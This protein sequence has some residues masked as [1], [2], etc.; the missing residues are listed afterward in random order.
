VFEF[1]T[2]VAWFLLPLPLLVWL[3]IPPAK[4]S[5]Q[6]ALILPFYADIKTLCEKKARVR[7]YR[8]SRLLACLVWVLGV[9]AL[10]GPQW[11]GKP[12]QMARAG[13]NILLAI[14]VS[15]SMETPDMLV[16]G[17]RYDR[18]SLVKAVAKRFIDKREGDRL[19]LI[20]FGSRAYLQTPLTY[21]RK[22]VKAQLED[23]TIGLAGQRTA[24]GDAIGAA[25]KRLSA[26]PQNARVLVLLTDGASNAGADPIQ[27]AKM[28]AKNHIRIY[29][30]GLGGDKIPVDTPFGVQYRQQSS[31]LDPHTLK[32]IADL[33]GG[34]FFRA[35]NP[36]SLV[37][38]YQRLNDLEPVTAES[39]AYRPVTPLYH[40]PLLAAFLIILGFLSRPVQ[41]SLTR[42][43]L[44]NVL[45]H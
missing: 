30:I 10:A 35:D 12:I 41:R 23:A 9:C 7:K 33:T 15:G 16:K 11:L 17:K 27:A 44:H 38:A 19:G 29:T 6:P 42:R 31:D 45:D 8:L 28:A 1:A 26:L 13:R 24:I 21:D 5:S 40:W 2:P 14:D 32:T 39:T 18:L 3:L 34:L 36:A 22:T 43:R 4:R 20:L 37:E 25:V